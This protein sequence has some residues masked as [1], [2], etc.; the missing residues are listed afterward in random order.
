VASEML[1][2]LDLSQRT[3]CEDLLAKDIGDFFDR[4]TFLGL[5]IGSSTMIPRVS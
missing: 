4:N 3:L 2:Q 1:E 5:L